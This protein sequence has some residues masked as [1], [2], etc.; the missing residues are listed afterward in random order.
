MTSLELNWTLL[1]GDRMVGMLNSDRKSL[2]D[3]ARRPRKTNGSV[4]S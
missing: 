2:A 4:T 1:N 3:H